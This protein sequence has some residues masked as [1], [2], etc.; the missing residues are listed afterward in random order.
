MIGG[1]PLKKG[2]FLNQVG[3]RGNLSSDDATFNCGMQQ[4]EMLSPVFNFY[5]A[6]EQLI[7]RLRGWG[8]CPEVWK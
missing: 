7:R 4:W 1:R 3:S 6:V 2:G 5:Q 8:C